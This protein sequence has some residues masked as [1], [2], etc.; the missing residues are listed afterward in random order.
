MMQLIRPS[1][2]DKHHFPPPLSTSPSLYP[3]SVSSSSSSLSPS[4][5]YIR[6]LLSSHNHVLTRAILTELTSRRLKGKEGDG[7]DH[8]TCDR[9]SSLLLRLHGDLCSLFLASLGFDLAKVSHLSE[10]LRGRSISSSLLQSIWKED[11]VSEFLLPFQT[12]LKSLSAA[13]VK[14]LEDTS[15]V[16]SD[17]LR[18]KLVSYVGSG[19]HADVIPVYIC[20]LCDKCVDVLEANRHLLKG[21]EEKEKKEKK[22]KERG[23]SGDSVTQREGEKLIWWAVGSLIFLRFLIPSLMNAD[24][25]AA[26]SAYSSSFD[27]RFSILDRKVTYSL[28]DKKSSFGSAPPVTTSSGLMNANAAAQLSCSSSSSSS[29]SSRGP[30]LLGRFLMKLCTHSDSLLSSSPSPSPSPSPHTLATTLRECVIHF[31]VFCTEVQEIGRSHPLFPPLPSPLSQS[32]SPSHTLR[33]DGGVDDDVTLRCE[34]ADFI[35]SCAPTLVTH[36][37][38]FKNQD[39]KNIQMLKKYEIFYP[40]LELREIHVTQGD[41][42]DLYSQLR[43]MLAHIPDDNL[44]K[45]LAAEDDL[46]YSPKSKQS[47]RRSFFKPT[48]ANAMSSQRWNASFSIRPQSIKSPSRSKKV[49][50]QPNSTPRVTSPP[51]TPK[52]P[53]S[54][55]TPRSPASPSIP[56]SPPTSSRSLTLSVSP[57]SPEASLSPA[58]ASSSTPFSP[59]VGVT[60]ISPPNV[61]VTTDSPTGESGAK[62][63]KPMNSRSTSAKMISIGVADQPLESDAGLFDRDS[64]AKGKDR[65]GDGTHRERRER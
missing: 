63:D 40:N 15:D 48:H 28:L 51:K 59:R 30:I 41:F 12:L 3:P 2:V 25:S 16:I 10:I 54:P 52:F 53:P 46:F 18:E 31:R 1:P 21:E 45:D 9:L 35:G 34:L 19:L 50:A 57:H 64:T 20:S 56:L 38:T 5:S 8:V 17:S 6:S 24:S 29:F 61:S 33:G 37:V 32:V 11:D 4:L 22:E 27:R 43:E 60:P 14:E 65:V 13:E 47:V 7:M 39:E 42:M 62:K 36:C 44:P 55:R 26:P 49:T 58:G 23:E